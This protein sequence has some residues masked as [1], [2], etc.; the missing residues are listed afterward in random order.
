MK[1]KIT[2]FAKAE[3]KKIYQYYSEVASVEIAHKIKDRILDTAYSLNNSP[4]RRSIE[5]NLEDLNEG[6]RYLLSGNYKIIY[7]VIDDVVF[8]T[9]V[10]DCRQDPEKIKQRE[11]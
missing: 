2:A 1:V 3:L 6:H 9:D 4:L 7:K 10:F 11:K 8:I 5:F